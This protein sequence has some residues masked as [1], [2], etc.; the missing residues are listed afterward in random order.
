LYLSGNIFCI[1][2]PLPCLYTDRHT[3]S[4]GGFFGFLSRI[5]LCTQAS[6][7]LMILL[8]SLPS[9]GVTGMHHHTWLHLVCFNSACVI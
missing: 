1:Y 6:L 9:A 7:E 2:I 5:L 3:V 4:C 8:L